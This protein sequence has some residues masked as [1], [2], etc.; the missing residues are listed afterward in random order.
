MPLRN[1]VIIK[2]EAASKSSFICSDS[3]DEVARDLTK[4]QSVSLNRKEKKQ[5]NN[6]SKSQ[7][8]MDDKE[9]IRKEW[10]SLE[11][12]ILEHGSIDK[13]GVRKVVSLMVRRTKCV[14]GTSYV[15]FEFKRLLGVFMCCC[16]QK[17]LKREEQLYKNANQKLARQLDIIN[18]MQT[19][20]RSKLLL[21]SVLD[22]RQRMLLLFQ[23]R[24]VVR[25]LEE[26]DD[27]TESETDIEM[28]FKSQLNDPNPMKRLWT[29]G[30]MLKK[31]GE[32]YRLPEA[33]MLNSIDKKLLQGIFKNRINDI[34]FMNREASKQ[35]EN[36]H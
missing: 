9:E 12:M 33:Q 19:I 30:K 2:D 35:P 18:V 31:V 36:T 10:E 7:S 14:L 6:L 16:R 25:D 17:R 32:Y 23:S 21:S 1:I 11:H 20:W 4:P 24:N 26:S 13:D 3:E 34:Q 15:F 22:S 8:N 28:Q 29:L 5:S 27:A